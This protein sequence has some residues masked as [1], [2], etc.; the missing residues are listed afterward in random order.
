MLMK[1]AKY[2][3][4]RIKFSAFRCDANIQSKDVIF[5]TNE[6]IGSYQLD[7]SI[8]YHRA[9]ACMFYSNINHIIIAYSA[10]FFFISLIIF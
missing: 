2:H 1:L 6:P 7:L 9:V 10:L 4:W 8:P 3:G 5:K